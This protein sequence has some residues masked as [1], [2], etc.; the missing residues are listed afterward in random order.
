M[1]TA[2]IPAK[3]A[4]VPIFSRVTADTIARHVIGAITMMTTVTT[5]SR[6]SACEL[7]IRFTV[8]VERP[9]QPAIGGM[10]TFT[11]RAH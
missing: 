8:V 3:T 7:K 5:E 11:L 2:T 1:T 9:Q 6:V 4:L 10:A